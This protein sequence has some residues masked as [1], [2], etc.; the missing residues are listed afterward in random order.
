MLCLSMFFNLMKHLFPGFLLLLFAT[1]P[2]LA[3]IHRYEVTAKDIQRGCVVQQVNIGEDVPVQ[4]LQTEYR[5]I[6]SLPK[7]VTADVAEHFTR[8]NG[9][10]RKVPFAILR[11]PAYTYNADGSFGV[12][13]SFS[14]N[15]VDPVP[16]RNS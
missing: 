9:V 6:S 12:L 2:T 11:I 7:G 13:M 14:L 4:I 16:A 1:S 3:S 10:E 8:M 5:P 15:Y